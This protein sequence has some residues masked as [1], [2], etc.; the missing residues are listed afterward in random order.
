MSICLPC[1]AT[2]NSG[3][4]FCA[5]CGKKLKIQDRYR[6][7]ALLGQ[8][9][10]GKTLLAQDEGKPSHPKCVIKQ[11]IYNDPATRSKALELFDEEAKRLEDLGQHPQIPELMAH[12]Q[13]DGHSYLVQQFI[14]GNNL[15]QELMQQGAF[16]EQQIRD[17]LLQLLP[18]LEFIHKKNVI[19]RDIKPENIMRRRSDKQLVLVDFGAAKHATA[20]T[21]AKTGT[22]IGSASYAAPEQAR[23][24]AV[25]AS[26]LY[27]LGVTCLHLLTGVDPFTL[28][29]DSTLGFAWRDFLNGKK[30]SDEIGKILDKMTQQRPID[31]YT[32]ATEA[33]QALGIRSI[34]SS[35][36]TSPSPTSIR[37]PITIGTTSQS[38][39]EMI[40]VP[41]GSC[42]MGGTHQ[43]SISA[44]AIGK[45]QITQAQ[46]EAEM[47]NNPSHF[48]GADLP[49]EEVS[50]HDAVAF[51]QKL[52]QQTGKKYRLPS[53]A[54]W[55]YACRAGS[56]TKYCF[57]DSDSQLKDYAWYDKNSGNKTRAVGQRKPNA[58]GLHDMH[59]NVWEWCADKWES[60]LSK[61]P[62]DG[63]VLL[64]GG[65]S[66]RHPIRGGSWF[67]NSNYC[68]SE[69][70]NND[71]A[72]F[73][74]YSLGFRVVCVGA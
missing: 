15:N 9:A 23:G 57:G 70:R 12:C 8:G 46:Y 24:R 27:G 6:A 40:T 29:D 59:G 53:E 34:P 4:S 67:Y 39:L 26:D 61:L 30:V 56:T 73:K 49:V 58:W 47:G 33:L 5:Q 54:E 11:F 66:S 21:L 55:E 62:K 19:H 20:T 7:H 51:C 69:Y 25:F 17:V 72:D 2:N 38:Q 68:R 1:N 16:G 60:D 48:K 13:Q 50:W 37:T 44:F 42:K 18:V 43:V 71:S 74:Y 64:S 36:T 28:I 31:R 22:T 3:A 45:Y 35:L 32:S 63:K 52:S 65:D 41:S 14:D 10:F